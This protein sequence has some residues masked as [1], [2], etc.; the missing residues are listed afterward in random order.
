MENK[1]TKLEGILDR[2]KRNAAL[3]DV[4]YASN[5]GMPIAYSSTLP[6]TKIDLVS[7]LGAAKISLAN[8]FSTSVY[9]SSTPIPLRRFILEHED[10]R[11]INGCRR[12]V[13]MPLLEGILITL[14]SKVNL[15]LVLLEMRKAAQ[16]IDQTI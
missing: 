16:I 8:D 5:E 12:V 14:S 13:I 11:R 1:Q 2:L 15:G 6:E 10:P 4:V 3:L 9:N 7:A